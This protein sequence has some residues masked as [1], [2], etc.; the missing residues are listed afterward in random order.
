M[1]CK[2]YINLY[3]ILFLQEC[4][5]ASANDMAKSDSTARQL[6][7]HRQNILKQVKA[8][9]SHL[10]HGKQRFITLLA[11][12]DP[13]GIGSTS[14]EELEYVIQ[15]TKPPISEES[16]KLV[17]KSLP[18]VEGGR[19]DY[20]PL[21][22]GD[23]VQC[24][25]QYTHLEIV[26]SKP[27]QALPDLPEKC[28]QTSEVQQ[29]FEPKCS[30][31]QGTTTMSGDRGTLSTAYKEEEQRQFEILL[32]FCRESGIVLN[33]ELLEKGKTPTF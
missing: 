30:I 22:K 15:K 19:L 9:E 17:L 20:R 31:A 24:V 6:R 23:I 25:K 28:S 14:A 26:D 11:L 29:T 4:V 7:R 2:A 18:E 1:S 3:F 12:H 27:H 32:E 13:A 21:V 16:L 8:L 10:L 33:Q 5:T